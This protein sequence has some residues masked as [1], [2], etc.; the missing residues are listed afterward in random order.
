MLAFKGLGEGVDASG[1]VG[2]DVGGVHGLVLVLGLEDVGHAVAEHAVE[3]CL[4]VLLQEVVDATAGEGGLGELLAFLVVEGEVLG[5]LEEGDEEEALGAAVSEGVVEAPS[6]AEHGEKGLVVPVVD[7][8]P[9][10][11][12]PVLVGLELV[13]E[14]VG[15]DIGGLHDGEVV[16]GRHEGIEV[17]QFVGVGLGAGDS[18]D[19]AI[20][21][22]GVDH[23]LAGAAEAVEGV[24]DDLGDEL[25]GVAVEAKGGVGGGWYVGSEVAEGDEFGL[26]SA[27]SRPCGAFRG[28]RN[29]HTDIT[30]RRLPT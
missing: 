17:P 14:V 27:I 9:R 30:F 5:G 28:S 11:A 18:S 7:L 8:A 29:G 24:R 6:L 21:G 12:E 2:L 1:D 16:E 13:D 15:L 10:R 22:K 25:G 23:G 20:A 3:L 19:G 4:P 26:G